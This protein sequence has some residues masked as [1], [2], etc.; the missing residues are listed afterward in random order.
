MD[1]KELSDILTNAGFRIMLQYSQSGGSL[2]DIEVE[3]PLILKLLYEKE[4]KKL[5]ELHEL[6]KTGSIK[7][8]A[9]LPT[10]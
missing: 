10:L 4:E 5:K 2:C 6:I 3:T 8:G 7:T 1:Y 9:G